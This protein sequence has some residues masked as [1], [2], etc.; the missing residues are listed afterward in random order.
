MPHSAFVWVNTHS[1]YIQSTKQEKEK[2]NYHILFFF[3]SFF[4][5]FYA[6]KAWIIHGLH[7]PFHISLIQLLSYVMFTYVMY[8]SNKHSLINSQ[9]WRSTCG[10]CH[11]GA[12]RIANLNF[13]VHTVEYEAPPEWREAGAGMKVVWRRILKP[14]ELWECVAGEGYSA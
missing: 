5:K 12:H 8:M 4:S 6:S 10:H 7:E 14:P 1:G 3:F 2:Y 11:L 13:L 9:S